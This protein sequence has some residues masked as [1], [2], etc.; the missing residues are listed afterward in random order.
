MAVLLAGGLTAAAASLDGVARRSALKNNDLTRLR[1][2]A[3]TLFPRGSR[4]DEAASQLATIGFACEDLQHPLPDISAPSLRCASDGRGY[5][6]YPSV[7]VILLTRN[8]LISDVDVWNIMARADGEPDD[9]D[10]TAIGASQALPAALRRPE[11]RTDEAD[12]PAPQF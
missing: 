8:G 4:L 2:E 12:R 9:I 5:P 10:F 7:N 3:L 1:A 6:N 11:P